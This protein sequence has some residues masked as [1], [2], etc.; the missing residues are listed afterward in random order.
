M[1]ASERILSHR[2]ATAFIAVCPISYEDFL[3]IKKASKYFKKHTQLVYFLSLPTMDKKQKK[4]LMHTLFAQLKLPHCFNDLLSLLVEQ[5]RAKLIAD[6]LY[7]IV[8]L[9]QEKNNIME[10]SIESSCA[11]DKK[12]LDAIQQFLAHRTG[13]DIIYTYREN[14][15]LIAGI[16]LQSDTLLWEYS[17]RK[18]LRA[19]SL[20]LMR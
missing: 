13:N 14:K 2:Y 9:Y 12:K 6:V 17:V 20:S 19:I 10:F 7:Y 18:K 16:R 1:T 3:F 15:N 8:Q 5:K 4:E 11:L